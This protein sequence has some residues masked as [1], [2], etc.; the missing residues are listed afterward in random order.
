M[1]SHREQTEKLS[2]S[3]QAEYLL[4][5]CRT[6]LPGIQALFGF[7]LMVVFN[8]GF[9]QKLTQTQQILHL[10][11]IGLVMGAVTIIMT[12]AAYHRQQGGREVTERFV[13]IST[14]LLLWSMVPLAIAL[15]FDFYLIMAMVVSEAWI[16]MIAAACFAFIV[17]FWFVLPR[18]DSLKRLVAGEPRE[19]VTTAPSETRPSRGRQATSS[20]TPG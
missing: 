15:C 8:D 20:G 12:P 19:D 11:A 3:Q 10:V 14:R 17:L 9:S 4:G 1:T 13:T 6:V 5:E 2:L 18:V 16:S 7:Q